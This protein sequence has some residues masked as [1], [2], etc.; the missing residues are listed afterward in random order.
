MSAPPPDGL[1]CL[2]CHGTKFRTVSR[3][4]QVPGLR[5]VYKRCTRAGCNGR[6]TVHEQQA[7][8]NVRRQGAN[9]PES[10]L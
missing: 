7:F 6:I 10:G 4:R 5:T 9:A 2:E 8:E 3:H 1:F